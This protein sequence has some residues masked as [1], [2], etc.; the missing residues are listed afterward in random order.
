MLLNHVL[1]ADLLSVVFPLAMFGYGLLEA[2]PS[3]RF[4]T[5]LTAYVIL[6]LW[7]KLLYQ[8]CHCTSTSEPQSTGCR[9]RTSN[10]ELCTGMRCRCSAHA[11]RRLL[12]PSVWTSG[13]YERPRCLLQ[14]SV[15]IMPHS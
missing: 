7:F 10:Y 13:S 12:Q 8:V 2:A 9:D 4:F 14:P 11:A 1:N 15:W 5:Y 3:R 6:V